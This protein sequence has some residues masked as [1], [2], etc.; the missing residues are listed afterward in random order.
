M[1]GL[2]PAQQEAVQTL[3]GP[4]LV[5]AGAGSGK[6]RGVV[7]YRIAKPH[8]ASHAGP[9]GFWAVT[10]TN[11]AATENAGTFDRPARQAKNNARKSALFHA[12]CVRVLRRHARKTRLPRTICDLRQGRSGKPRPQRA[13]RK[14][15]C[16][17]ET[18][19]PA[20]LLHQISRWKG[21]L[22]ASGRCRTRKPRS[23]KE[24]LASMGLPPLSDCAEKPLAP[25][26]FDDL[27]LLTEELFTQHADARQHEAQLFDH[28]LVDEYQDTSAVQY[29]IIAALAAGPSQPLR[30]RR[31]RPIHLRLA[32]GR[33]AA[34]FAFCPRLDRRQSHP[35][36]VEL[37]LH[38]RHSGNREPA[39]HV[40]QAP[41]RQSAPRRP[42]RAAIR[43]EFC[44]TIA[45]LMKPATTVADI[46]RRLEA[47][48]L[49]PR[50][51][52][53]FCSAPTS[54][55]GRL[56]RSCARLRFRMSFSAASRSSI[57]KRSRT[58]SL[59][60]ARSIR[61]GTK[62]RCSAS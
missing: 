50:D 31:R 12:H 15:A 29:R 14:F 30:R 44:N 39:H 40:Q 56:R 17:S 52:G 34:H 60:C 49:E 51:S 35:P 24:H 33:S 25:S 37:S 26:I 53:D 1:S 58:S 6:K 19:R 45:R 4:M 38:L 47:D 54:S 32:R 18:M 13:A 20:D 57:A 42:A 21:P 9:S 3:A 46:R 10:F 62:S 23:D 43:R 8:Q 28:L 48:H 36:G 41:A 2:N 22:A 16:P 7:T 59:T 11:K 5:L 27:L 61:R 55:R